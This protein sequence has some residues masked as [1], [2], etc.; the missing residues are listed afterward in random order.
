MGGRAPPGS[1]PAHSA[2]DYREHVTRAAYPYLQCLP[3]ATADFARG[4][5]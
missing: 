5:L 1:A 4:Q 2:F 3:S